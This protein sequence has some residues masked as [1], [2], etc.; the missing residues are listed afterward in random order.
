MWYNPIMKAILR[1][2]LH[3]LLSGS[4]M[5]VTYTGRRTG[6]TYTMPVNYVEIGDAVLVTS[7]PERSWWRSLRGGAPVLLHL[8]GAQVSAVASVL[9]DEAS[10][11]AA[12]LNIVQRIPA[13]RRY[14]GITLD[15]AG[16]PQDPAALARAAAQRVI[17]H[18]EDLSPLQKAVQ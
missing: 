11:S 14:L 13:Y 16:Q 7:L 1:S 5:L 18:V 12:L 15:A 3:G 17:I 10:Q 4:M 8:R 6:K 9:E 2:P